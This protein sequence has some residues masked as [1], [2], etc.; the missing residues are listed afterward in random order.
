MSTF[1]ALGKL[2]LTCAQD[3]GGE[4]G[5]RQRAAA[6]AASGAL[7]ATFQNWNFDIGICGMA[8]RT[9]EACAG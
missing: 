5:R 1:I 6:M 8:P 2:R 4:F 3:E 9:P 7:T